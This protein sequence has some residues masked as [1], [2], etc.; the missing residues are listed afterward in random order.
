MM[1]QGDILN[2]MPYSCV[3]LHMCSLGRLDPSDLLQGY[4]G[5]GRSSKTC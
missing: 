5:G 1:W 3:T 4:C 2:T